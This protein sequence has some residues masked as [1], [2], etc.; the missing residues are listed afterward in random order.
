MRGFLIA[1]IILI[2]G[3]PGR[4]QGAPGITEADEQAR[5]AWFAHDATG[6]VADSPRLMVRLPG[7]DPSA[8]LEPQQAA[9]LIADYLAPALEVET[10]VRAAREMEGGRGYVEIQRRYRVAGTQDV[11]IQSLLLGYR[12]GRT[13]W[14]LVELRV[15]G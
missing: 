10:V 2:S 4:A 8:A 7:A 14:L 5:R 11:R 12:K 9:A 15:V 1:A 6:L 13:G 3:T